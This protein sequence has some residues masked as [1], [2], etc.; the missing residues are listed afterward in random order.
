MAIQFVATGVSGYQVARIKN[1]LR[2]ARW[3][4]SMDSGDR[5]AN[6]LISSDYHG[7]RS[8]SSWSAYE[9]VWPQRLRNQTTL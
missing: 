1:P 4:L 8:T 3:S 9:Q 7:A 5:E 6:G 2:Q